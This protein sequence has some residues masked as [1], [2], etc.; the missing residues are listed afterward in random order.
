M[1]ATPYARA[2]VESEIRTITPTEA[3]IMLATMPD[4]GNR[5]LRV[6]HAE[7]LASLILSDNWV[8]SHQGIA[9]DQSGRLIDGQHRLTA[10]TIAE[11]PVEILVTL[12][13][14][15]EA[16]HGVDRGSTRTIADLM[17]LAHGVSGGSILTAVCRVLQRE[18]EGNRR[19]QTVAGAMQVYRRYQPGIDWVVTALPGRVAMSKAPV[20]AALALAY[21][22]APVVDP[23]ETFIASYRSGKHVDDREPAWRLREVVLRIHNQKREHLSD[24]VWF[25]MACNAVLAH[26]DGRLIPGVQRTRAGIETLCDRFELNNNGCRVPVGAA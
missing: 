25:A 8:I 3:S 26:L 18:L 2:H 14:Q 23:L 16:I 22:T 5:K 17:R 10:I 15:A 13:L 12:G 11:R 19:A 9:F 7:T 24:G 20:R 21:M 1:K 6:S 4:G